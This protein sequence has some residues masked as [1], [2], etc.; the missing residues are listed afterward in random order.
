[1]PRTP[2]AFLSYV[3][4]NDKHDTGRLTELRKRLEQEVQVHTGEAFPIFQDRNDIQWGQQWKERIEESIDA[5]TFLIAIITPSY[6]KSP[7]CRDEFASFLKRE[8]KL[9]RND[10]LLPLLYIETPALSDERKRAKDKIAKEI[11]KRQW[12]DWRDL[13]HEPWTN[14]EVGKRL[15]NVAMQIRD[16][17]ERKIG[18]K[19]KSVKHPKRKHLAPL[20]FG[21]IIALPDL[22]IKEAELETQPIDRSPSGQTEAKIITVDS[23]AGRADC[24]TIGEAIR[25]ATGGE[26][27]LV[28]PGIYNEGLI[29]D[30]PLEIL[31]D[32]LREKIIVE[33]NTAN[34]LLTTTDFGRVA[35]LTLRQTGTA[36]WRCVNITQGRLQMEDCEITSQDLICL[37]VQGGA[38]PRV[39]R[40]II[41][42][43]KRCGVY[44]S[45]NA[46]GTF[47]D[48][49][50]YGHSQSGVE[51]WTG[52]DPVFR[53]NRIHNCDSSG[54]L[55]HS[56]GK[57]VLE[58]NEVFA[59]K[60]SGIVITKSG[61]PVIRRNRIHDNQSAGVSCSIESKGTLEDNEIFVNDGF[62]VVIANRANP[63]LRR[64]RIFASKGFGV[65]IADGGKGTLEENSIFANRAGGLAV[66][67]A[68]APYVRRNRINQNG[69]AAVYVADGGGVFE[70]NDLRDNNPRAWHVKPGCTDKTVR[71]GNIEKSSDVALL[72]LYYHGRQ[73]T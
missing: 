49:D 6:L 42:D 21:N 16:A 73:L 18:A 51:I 33:S 20:E 56:G 29:I 37:S 30:K 66:F 3:Q 4:L 58:D 55:V 13:R 35:N 72:L 17:I 10:L 24:Q 61:D 47:E 43:G 25:Q 7:T 36:G 32:G 44:L 67:S 19:P 22:I 27:I 50:I 70:E 5:S 9:K 46:K 71:N 60:F 57:G 39:R 38:D 59:N 14:P 23:T 69:I 65:I 31:G 2:A 68:G 53:R 40:C 48:N 34:T 52:G 1:M 41:H 12:A 28:R 8:K 63:T 11:A 62:G 45:D 54:V 64:N 15:A 26:R